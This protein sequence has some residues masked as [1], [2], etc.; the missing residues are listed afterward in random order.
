MIQ[1]VG[2]GVGYWCQNTV[3][4]IAVSDCIIVVENKF[5]DLV[6]RFMKNSTA[7]GRL[8]VPI[9]GVATQYLTAQDIKKMITNND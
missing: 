2:K 5:D 7:D 3:S 4:D 1:R 9:H 6:E 8:K